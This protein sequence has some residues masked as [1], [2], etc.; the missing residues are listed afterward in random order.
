MSMI[1]GHSNVAPQGK[2]RRAFQKVSLASKDDV[3]TKA[4]AIQ[5]SCS[6]EKQL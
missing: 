5:G 2:E 1:N 4:G 3:I 6:A